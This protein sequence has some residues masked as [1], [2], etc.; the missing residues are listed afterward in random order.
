VAASFVSVNGIHQY[1]YGL[2]EMRELIG[3]DQIKNTAMLYKESDPQNYSLYL[4][5]MSNRIFS[6]F[7]YPNSLSGYLCMIFPFLLELGRLNKKDFVR[8]YSVTAIISA[9]V[10]SIWFY[11]QSQTF[12]I[13]VSSIGALFFPVSI[14]LAFFFT[15]SKG[16]LITLAILV[17]V[18]I[19]IFL[20]K[21]IKKSGCISL[22][23]A[24]LI[25]SPIILFSIPSHKIKSFYA[26]LDYW[27]SSVMMIKDSPVYGFGLGSFGNVYPKYRLETAEET[28][29]AH[30]NYLQLACE[31]G[32]MGASIYF[33]L[34]LYSLIKFLKSHCHEY[35]GY[36][37]SCA[38]FA[39]LCFFIH[40]F[41]DFDL[42]I[43]ALGYYAFFMIGI[44]QTGLCKKYIFE[45]NVRISKLILIAGL[46]MLIYFYNTITD[47]F[48]A[49]Y[50]LNHAK[51]MYYQ[52]NEYEKPLDLLNLAITLDKKNGKLYFLK[53]NIYFNNKNFEKAVENYELAVY[54]ERHRSSYRYQLA[55]AL[56]MSGNPQNRKRAD[57]ELKKARSLN[58]Y[59]KQL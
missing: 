19:L 30:N 36:L 58:P 10:L 28:Q 52:K 48:K 3:I 12:F 57:T 32:V 55:Q 24:L 8:I 41:V 44:T 31:T 20:F 25:L 59:K 4:R 51:F 21:K 9:L 5:L 33:I 40:G 18:Y 45:L 27:K 14:C 23:F 13:P 43:P 1:F 53:G 38:G 7:V 37:Q 16:G 15:G 35:P 2:R 54:Y 49:Q 56:I 26:R 11:L 46:F 47:Y 29:F 17:F 42:F 50:L 39:L 22:S 34:L 6:T